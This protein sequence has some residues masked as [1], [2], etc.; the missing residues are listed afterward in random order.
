MFQLMKKNSSYI[1]QLTILM[2][3]LTAVWLIHPTP[4]STYQI[5]M[6]GMWLVL[7]LLG[8]AIN[9]EMIEEKMKGYA[10]LRTLPIKDR[11]IVMSKFL[12]AGLTA[13]VF[14]VHINILLGFLS[15]PSHLFA[16]G[17]ILIPL[18]AGIALLAV[19]LLYALVFR[20]GYSRFIKIAWGAFFVIILSPILILEFVLI[21]INL[22]YGQIINSVI[23]LPWL[24]WLS[25]GLAFLAVYIGL[26]S[27]AVKAKEAS[28][29]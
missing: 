16:L 5:F 7:V 20:I 10:F 18:F 6:G 27:L 14:V 3:L 26:M 1:I 8:G 4:M 17:R 15:G 19:A 23:T 25:A 12:M 21:K 13:C 2:P 24:V 29:G 28:K 9:G 11:D 22:D